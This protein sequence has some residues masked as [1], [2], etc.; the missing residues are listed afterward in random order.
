MFLDVKHV[1]RSYETP[2]SQLIIK[3]VIINYRV[4]IRLMLI[5]KKSFI[6]GHNV[7]G[8]I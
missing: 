7:S 1:F 3:L 2:V 8:D 4:A 5:I 6:D